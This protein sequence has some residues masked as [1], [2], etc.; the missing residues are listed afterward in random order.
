MVSLLVNSSGFILFNSIGGKAPSF[1]VGMKA[2]ITFYSPW[3]L[4]KSDAANSENQDSPYQR[5]RDYIM[6]FVGEVPAY[7]QFWVS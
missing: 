2:E 1:T 4:T 7:L 5:A 6:G 3:R